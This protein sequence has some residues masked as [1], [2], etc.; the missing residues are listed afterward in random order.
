VLSVPNLPR[1][2]EPSLRRTL[3]SIAAVAS[4]TASLGWVLAQQAAWPGQR[5]ATGLLGYAVIGLAVVLA[6]SSRLRG[7]SFGLPNQITLLR[8]A[9]ACLVGSALLANGQAPIES[10]SVSTLVAVALGLD[11]LDGRLARR[12]GRVSAFGARFDME[13]DALLILMLALLVWQAGRVDV[14][15][16]AIGSMRY[17]FVLAGLSWSWLR[18]PLP[19]SWRRQAVCVIQGLALWVCMLPPVAPWL[20]GL[21]AGGALSALAASFAADIRWLR[22]SAVASG[23]GLPG[24][25]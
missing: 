19:P 1:V 16:L 7:P 15:V 8:A 23:S 14:W 17:A 13:V 18:R 5:V 24:A 21:A 6:A 10:W 22:L 12:L 4:L 3:A 9:L 20:A 25:R 2:A 11:A